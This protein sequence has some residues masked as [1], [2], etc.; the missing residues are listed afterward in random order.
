MRVEV[1]SVHASTGLRLSAGPS[2]C[3]PLGPLVWVGRA[4]TRGN[5]VQ[6]THSLPSQADTP[7]RRERQGRLGDSSEA[8][9]ES[10]VG[11]LLLLLP[12]L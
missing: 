6:V 2:A 9:P 11:F 8:L 1:Y 7:R 5:K 10:S 4:K 12:E 3:L